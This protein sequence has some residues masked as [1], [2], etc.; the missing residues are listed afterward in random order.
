MLCFTFLSVGNNCP[1]VWF[2]EHNEFGAVSVTMMVDP[3]FEPLEISSGNLS[4]EQKMT[5]NALLKTDIFWKVE[6][7]MFEVIGLPSLRQELQEMV[8]NHAK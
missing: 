6:S 5:I 3:S 8:N 7:N 2:Q 1:N 4:K